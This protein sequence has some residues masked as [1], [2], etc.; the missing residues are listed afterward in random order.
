MYMYIVFIVVNIGT[1]GR[2]D[3]KNEYRSKDIHPQRTS[4]LCIS[5]MFRIF[6]CLVFVLAI[7]VNACP[8][9]GEPL[10]IT[11]GLPGWYQ[12]AHSFEIPERWKYK[13]SDDCK[14]I[15]DTIR[16]LYDPHVERLVANHFQGEN[17]QKRV[18]CN[19]Q[20]CIPKKY[21]EL[22]RRCIPVTYPDWRVSDGEF[23]Y[24]AEPQYDEDE[25]L[26]AC[27]CK[28]IIFQ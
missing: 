18:P 28:V 20:Y 22:T 10:N 9:R 25:S 1:A 23:I 12:P 24:G 5:T 11:R 4:L 7:S 8:Q 14:A 2:L 16:G 19:A 13:S 21:L 26:V 17:V 27:V 6:A 3:V 15:D